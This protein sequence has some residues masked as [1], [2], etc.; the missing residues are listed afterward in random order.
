MIRY[1][2]LD[3][4][5]VSHIVKGQ[6]PA[7]RVKLAGLSQ[8][9]VGCISSITEAEI[10]FGLAKKPN[11]HL[12]RASIEGFL[13]KIQILDWGREAAAAYG[14]LRAKLESTGKTLGNLDMLIA[15]H[16]IA[17]GAVLVTNNKRFSEAEAL[18]TIAKWATDL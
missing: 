18:S 13:A 10:R 6:S 7:A 4:N 12:L 14:D 11:A 15:A 9:E 5:T 2:M 16:A 17:V 3:T 8:D 1:F